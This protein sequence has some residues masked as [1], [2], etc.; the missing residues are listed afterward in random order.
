LKAALEGVPLTKTPEIVLPAGTRTV[1]VA[2]IPGLLAQAIHAE[3][4]AP[5]I[6]KQIIKANI[7][8][9]GER[10]GR[11]DFL[12][13]EDMALLVDIL[14]PAP[15]PG[16]VT[17]DEQWMAY[18]SPWFSSPRRPTWTPGRQCVDPK[19]DAAI[20][21]AAAEES[22]KAALI[23]AI[24]DGSFIPLNHA[25]VPLEGWTGELLGIGQV[26][27]PEFTKYAARFGIAVRIE[28]DRVVIRDLVDRI[29]EATTERHPEKWQNAD[30]PIVRTI[31]VNMNADG[32]WP[33]GIPGVLDFIC[34]EIKSDRVEAYS[35]FNEIRCDDTALVH[36]NPAQWY[37]TQDGE[38]YLLQA[39]GE[40]VVHTQER[41][42]LQSE[43]NA[44]QRSA[45][46]LAKQA[47]GRYTIKE[48]CAELFKATG[49]YADRWKK[50]ML[51]SIQQGELP[52][53]NPGVYSDRL[54]YAVPKIIHSFIEEVDA[55]GLNRWLDAH[56]EWNVTFRFHRPQIGIESDKYTQPVQVTR[57]R[58][59]AILKVITG[60]GYNAHALPPNKPGIKGV[61]S[62]IRARF[63]YSPEL[64][65]DDWQRLLNRGVDGG[66]KYASEDPTPG[67]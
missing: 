54:P 58:E 47:A 27:I 7:G 41:A 62:E 17:T 10:E 61:K 45:N 40:A 55:D 20:L 67:K 56:S 63:S 33:D 53:R 65:D 64:F 43:E 6:L 28:S 31:V 2:E 21:R 18:V 24:R 9:N 66:I 59:L 3:S 48:A 36:A 57:Q 16:E 23:A 13:D 15:K 32:W 46:E 39:I 25:M 42:R 49:I 44:K 1:Q 12:T 4:D 22:H 52:L 26:L 11:T 14:G 30:D 5:V 51:N 34:K 19:L 50:T 60:L 35:V 38:R 8:P 37:V 29:A